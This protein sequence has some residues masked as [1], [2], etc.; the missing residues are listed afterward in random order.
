MIDSDDPIVGELLAS[1]LGLVLEA[2]GRINPGARIVARDHQLHVECVADGT[3]FNVP[4]TAFVRV[5]RATY[6]D[7]LRVLQVDESFTEL[8]YEL[9]VTATALATATHKLAW[10]RRTHP[11][12]VRELPEDLVTSVREVVPSFRTEPIAAVDLY[13][14]NR[15]FRMDLGDGPERV[16][17]PLVDLLNHHS[18]GATGELTDAQ[19]TVDVARPFGTNECALDYGMDRDALTFAVVY[20]FLDTSSPDSELARRLIE[21]AQSHS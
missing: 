18:L 21:A 17:I 19:F 13:W 20:G 7:E 8:E 11:S 15:C 1:L 16:L 5:D 2:G 3:L 12:L 10:M 14:A 4:R 6:D 9:L